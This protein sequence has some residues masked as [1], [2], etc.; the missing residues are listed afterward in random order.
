LAAGL[1]RTRTVLVLSGGNHVAIPPLVEARFKIPQDAADEA[2]REFLMST[3][4]LYEEWRQKTEQ[5]GAERMRKQD[6]FETYETRFGAIPADLQAVI[7]ATHDE[8]TL[9]AW[10][11][12]AITRSADEIAA[13]IHASRAS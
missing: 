3:Q 4:D 9:H 2:E 5:V 8:P 12:L 13:A 11:K 10:F 1:S 7:E 6:L